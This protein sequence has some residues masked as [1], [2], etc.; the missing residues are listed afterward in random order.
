M[1]T[2]ID[3]GLADQQKITYEN[4]HLTPRDVFAA[5]LLKHIPT[6]GEDVILL[7]VQSQGIKKGKKSIREYVLID[8]YDTLH[9][10]TAMMRMTGYPVSIT[11][12]MIENG[13]ISSR[14]VFCP[15]EIIPPREFFKQ[16]EKRDISLSIRNKSVLS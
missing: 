1:R 4:H 10:I 14:G 8:Y 11:A 7:K 2:F 9:D 6:S 16:L 3:L 13:T 5:L 15:E 12:Q